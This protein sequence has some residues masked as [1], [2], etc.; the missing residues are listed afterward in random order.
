M[1]S[2]SCRLVS[3]VVPEM[4][5]LLCLYISAEVPVSDVIMDKRSGVPSQ[6]LSTTSPP[7]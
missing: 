5:F 7:R 2:G 3:N 4:F 6:R 1:I